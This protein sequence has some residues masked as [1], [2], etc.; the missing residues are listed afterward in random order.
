MS[1]LAKVSDILLEI[2]EDIKD[3]KRNSLDTKEIS[4]FCKVANTMALVEGTE[5]RQMS[6]GDPTKGGGT[7]PARNR[8]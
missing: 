4:N 3:K 5:S 2:A 6:V 1:N 8:G 7:K